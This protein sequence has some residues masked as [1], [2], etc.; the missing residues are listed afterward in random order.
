MKNP[1]VISF[2]TTYAVKAQ[3]VKA[4][5]KEKLK[6]ADYICKAAMAAIEVKP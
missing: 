4:A 6:L 1:A 2:R 3:L 5:K